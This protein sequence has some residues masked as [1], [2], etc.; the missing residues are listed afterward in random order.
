MTAPTL[1]EAIRYLDEKQAGTGPRLFVC[2]GCACEVV[3]VAIEC[4][5]RC[6]SARH[7]WRRFEQVEPGA[8]GG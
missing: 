8:N 7:A 3:A 4:G 6:P 2:P 1:L 5:H